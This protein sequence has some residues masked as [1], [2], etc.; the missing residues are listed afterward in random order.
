LGEQVAEAEQAGANRIHVDVINGHFVPN[1]S[2]GTEIVRSLRRVTRLPLEVHFMVTDPDSYD[3]ERA[4]HRVRQPPAQHRAARPVHDRHQVQKAPADREV[5]DVGRPHLVGLS[6]HQVAQQVGID[7]MAR[8]RFARTP[9]GPQGGD[10]PSGAS[11]AG[12][13][14]A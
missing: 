5:G 3:T 10:A 9:L 6:D 12:T 8:C 13:A 11:V 7:R 14:T 1:L 4:V 2:M